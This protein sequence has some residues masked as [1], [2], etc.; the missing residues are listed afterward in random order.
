M[1][2][3]EAETTFVEAVTPPSPG[4]CS[5]Q[6]FSAVFYLP[7][8]LNDLSNVGFPPFPHGTPHSLL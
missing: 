8:C 5:L 1:D 7:E 3:R 2:P 6:N 4:H